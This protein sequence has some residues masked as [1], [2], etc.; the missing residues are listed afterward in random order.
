MLQ[1]REN[2]GRRPNGGMTTRP[3]RKQNAA[4]STPTTTLIP[5]KHQGYLLKKKKV[6]G[7]K[8]VYA[9]LQNGHLIYYHNEYILAYILN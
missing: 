5:P 2:S 4:A 3:A 8:Q 6:V 9:V 7:F 1:F